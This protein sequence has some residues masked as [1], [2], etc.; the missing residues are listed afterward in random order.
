MVGHIT[1]FKK[2][3]LS[4]ILSR[5]KTVLGNKTTKKN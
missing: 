2:N 4:N 1:K 3:T 5:L